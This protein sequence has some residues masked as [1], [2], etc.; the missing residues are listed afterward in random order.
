[1]SSTKPE[2][3]RNRVQGVTG[4]IMIAASPEY[5]DDERHVRGGA[6]SAHGHKE[7]PIILEVIRRGPARTPRG[8]GTT[9][10][11]QSGSVA[12]AAAVT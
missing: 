10:R 12:L 5:R 9:G 3:A 7:P 11:T 8:G 1:M 2:T 4:L 6:L